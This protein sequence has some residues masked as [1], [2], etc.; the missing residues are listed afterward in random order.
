MLWMG[1][2]FSESFSVRGADG[3]LPVRQSTI[4]HIP[5]SRS[6]VLLRVMRSSVIN[7]RYV[8]LDWGVMLQ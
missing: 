3:K 1:N 7:H 6:T 5:G 4:F 8:F 2:G